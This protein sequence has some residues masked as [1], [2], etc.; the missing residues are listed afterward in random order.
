MASHD[1]KESEGIALL[2]IYGDEDDEE[3]EE[4]DDDDDGDG[5]GKPPQEQFQLVQVEPE[6]KLQE[7]TGVSTASVVALDLVVQEE[8]KEQHGQQQRVINDNFTP[9]RVVGGLWGSAT[10][11]PQD[12]ISSPALPPLLQQQLVS[13]R[14]ERMERIA[15]VDYGHDEVAMSP[16]PEEGEIMVGENSMEIEDAAMING[17]IQEKTVLVLTPS[18]RGTPQISDP[19]DQETGSSNYVVIGSE[20]AEA[21][22]ADVVPLKEPKDIDPLTK[23]LPPPPEAKCSDELQEKISKFLRLKKIKSYNAE[24][25]NR[26][27][28]RNPDF[29]RHAMIYHDIDE[30]GS[31]F[32]KDVFDPHGYNKK[33]DMRR[34]MERK[35]QER[36]RSPKID[37]L[38]AGTQPGSV[39]TPKISLP[40]PVAPGTGLNTISAAVDTLARDGRHNKKSKWDKV[41]GDRLNLLPTVAQDSVSAVA[42]HAAL[43]SA[44][45]AG[46]GYSAYAQQRRREAEDKQ[47]S[48]KKSDRRT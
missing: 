15:I 17:D 33:L 20:S 2:S 12:S 5:D 28:Y 6:E 42:T 26:K 8:E 13:Q 32:S 36:K 41:D 40:I 43:L 7:D 27:E 37:F 23:F 46:S 1:K 45:N 30:I 38:S 4:I 21:E 35:E 3:M 9:D 18:H 11:T 47:S 10:A 34:E 19:N 14:R 25:R 29:L 39:P 31:C 48:D 16:E 24:V 44:A 22:D